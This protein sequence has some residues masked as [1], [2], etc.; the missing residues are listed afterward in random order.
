MMFRRL[1]VAAASV[2]LSVLLSSCQPEAKPMSAEESRRVSEL[3]A[4]M[5][6]RCVGRYLVDLPEPFVLNPFSTT[7]IEDV[8][9]TVLPMT[10]GVFDLT[11][12]GRQAELRR[13][14]IDGEDEPTLKSVTALPNRQGLVFDRA[15]TPSDNFRRTLELRAWRTEF[16]ID[17]RID[18]DDASYW[19]G[20][21]KRETTT[22]QKLAHLLRVF[23]RL[24][25][26]ADTD[27]PTEQG[28]CLPNG[29]VRGAPTDQESLTIHYKLR[30][31]LDGTFTIYSFSGI[32]PEKT[33]LLERG[34]DIE[35]NLTEVGGKTLR[36]GKRQANG[37]Q[38]EEWLL[39]RPNDRGVMM[40]DLTLE[41]NSKQGNAQAPQF[42]FDF[43]SG[44][45]PARDTSK[46]TLDQSASRKRIE[47]A[48][49]NAAESIAIW[50]KVTPTLRKRPGA[51]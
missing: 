27:I 51:F 43:G 42:V 21:S 20:T 45:E 14:R 31:S 40:Y 46:E 6:A 30:D 33:T 1:G 3:T 15:K 25:V 23:E 2:T 49:F 18:A 50:D 9:I 47:K 26:R 36:T 28:V 5:T 8:A 19:T 48:T 39:Q 12:E 17:M 11:L 35:K 32:G 22:P 16:S 13:E 10:R 37:L 7:E 24:Q 34:P 38:F 41:M 29:F 44:M 4:R